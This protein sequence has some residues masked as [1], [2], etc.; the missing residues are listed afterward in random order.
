MLQKI[1]SRNF[2]PTRLSTGITAVLLVSAAM[3]FQVVIETRVTADPIGEQDFGAAKVVIN[4]D[5]LEDRT[6]VS[7]QFLNLGVQF[8]NDVGGFPGVVR[9][10]D[11]ARSQ[12]NFLCGGAA[13]S[14]DQFNPDIFLTFT[15]PVTALGGI[16]INGH[17]GD[18]FL[19]VFGP[20]GETETVTNNADALHL[21]VASRP[22]FPITRAQFGGTVFCIDDVTFERGGCMTNVKRLSQGDPMWANDLCDH[23]TTKT[24]KRKGC[25]L[26]SLSMALNFAGLANDPG[27]LNQFMIKTDHDYSGADVSWG[28]TT[29]DRSDGTLVFNGFR[30]KAKQDLDNALCKGFPVIVGVKLNARGKPGHYV[31]VTGKQ[32]NR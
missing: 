5:S 26:T 19:R 13:G 32:G 21:F 4:F 12:P 18:N 3:L 24:I 16:I 30:S 9:A 7:I 23:S 2:T 1:Y 15:T 14:H 31:V 25:A 29:R 28:A 20:N 11:G 17:S 22:S 10:T 27:S 8:S 6:P